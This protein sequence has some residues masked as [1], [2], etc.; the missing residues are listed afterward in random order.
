MIVLVSWVD[1]CHLIYPVFWS[2][3]YI[4]GY[5]PLRAHSYQILKVLKFWFLI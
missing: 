3:L 4:L 1:S 5:L 2:L